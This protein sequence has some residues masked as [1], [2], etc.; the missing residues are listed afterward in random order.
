M[1]FSKTSHSALKGIFFS[2]FSIIVFWGCDSVPYKDVYENQTPNNPVDTTQNPND[3]NFLDFSQRVFLEDFTGHQC[4][5]C[6]F[7]GD[8]AKRLEKK[9][10]GK[11]VVMAVHCGFYARV[12]ANPNSVKYK[13]DFRTPVGNSIDALVG[14]SSAGLPKGVVQRKAFEGT[15]KISLLSH[16]DWDGK[17]FGLLNEPPSGIGINLKPI[18]SSGLIQL[19][20]KVGFQKPYTG[21]INQAVYLVED[22]I[23][24]WQKK[25][26][27]PGQSID[28]ENYN[29]MHILRGGLLPVDGKIELSE[30]TEFTNADLIIKNWSGSLPNPNPAI[31]F[32]NTSLIYILFKDENQ[33]VLQVGKVAIPQ[34]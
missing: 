32:K 6:P 9:Y 28:I 20:V 1:A 18:V 21:K 19:R 8:E 26:P 25:Y 14:A 22:S 5:N 24:S 27:V 2:L 17:I 30:K 12:D 13:A 10:E 3:T 33:E 31:K 23:I 7:A 29:H 15:S 34:N 4:G 11:V 16:S